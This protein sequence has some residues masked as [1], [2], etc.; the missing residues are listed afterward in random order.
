MTV[1]ISFD[2]DGINEYK[3]MVN[4]LIS[5]VSYSYAPKKLDLDLNNRVIPPTNLLLRSLSFWSSSLIL[6]F[7]VMYFYVPT[8]LFWL[9]FS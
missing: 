1:I 8:K 2:S 6:L 7:F 9:S 3:E 4:T 5:R